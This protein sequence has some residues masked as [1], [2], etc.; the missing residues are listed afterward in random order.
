MKFFYFLLI[1]FFCLISARNIL[2]DE[3]KNIF[4]LHL[5]QTQDIFSA[6]KI[7]NS[8]GGDWGW[9]TIVLRTDQ[10][11]HNTWQDFFDNCRRLHLIPIIRLATVM[12]NDSWQAPA[13]QDI[14]NLANFLNSLNWPGAKQYVI[15]FN[16]INHASEWGGKVN[17][18]DYADIAVYAARKFKNLNHD[19]IIIG[20][21]LD[22]AAP[23]NPGSYKSAPN[24]YREIYSYKPE[25]FSIIDA[26]ASHSYPNH[27]F[28]GKP[29]DTGQH[30][31]HGYRWELDFLK[32]LG[33]Q[34]KYPVIISETGWPHR[35][36][37]S[38]NNQF[39]T[40][41]TSADFLQV[42]LNNWSKDSDIIAVTPFIYNY[43]Y[44]P[45]DHFSWVDKTETIYSEYNNL[46]ALPKSR[47]NFPQ[48][49]SYS[50]VNL[51]LPLLLFPDKDYSGQITLKN[52][53]QSIWGE[54]QF[55]LNPQTTQN[56]T[57]DMICTDNTNVLPGQTHTFNFNLKINS[58]DKV[59]GKT[60]IS[61]QNL[62][63][64]EILAIDPKGSI[65][66]Q[67]TGIKEAIITFFT[68]LFI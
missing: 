18:Q 65:Y 40:V 60:F 17:V 54:T 52:T 4:G 49:T 31:V 44:P 33:I 35:E 42:A 2:A 26:L 23:E 59:N 39:Y 48:T 61:W 37:E 36:G 15:L 63:Q 5:T 67:K 29:S 55:C 20:G 47:N 30:S 22:L 6:A 56:I 12:K 16:E 7:I 25:Y 19:F 8:G 3:G 46:T 53:G 27:G 57:L 41:K 34:K 38:K 9:V 28:I 13:Y 21:A 62:P 51:G 1:G 11:D 14:D 45:F 68:N 43:P 32:S 64:Y 66:S 10:L 58:K 24:V 50:V